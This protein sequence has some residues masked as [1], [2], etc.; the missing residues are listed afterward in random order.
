MKISHTWVTDP[1]SSQRGWGTFTTWIEIAG[2]MRGIRTGSEWMLNNNNE[3]G[4]THRCVDKTWGLG[5]TRLMRELPGSR[6]VCPAGNA[7]GHVAEDSVRRD[8]MKPQTAFSLS[9]SC[10]SSGC[11]AETVSRD[12]GGTCCCSVAKS[13]VTLCDPMNCST[14]DSLPFTIS[15]SSLKLMSF[16]SVML[17][18]Y[19]ILCSPL[20]LFSSLFPSIRWPKYWGFGFSINPSREYSGLISF[21]V[22]WFDLLAVQAT[23][24]S[25]LQHHNLKASV[26]QC[27]ASFM[28]KES[29]FTI[30]GPSRYSC[31]VGTD[32]RVCLLPRQYTW[33]GTVCSRNLGHPF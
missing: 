23:L 11:L 32:I 20:L 8:G 5:V 19:L 3:K 14:P 33:S 13:C 25:L 12:S 27:S 15:W 30:Q 24:K 28:V 10:L 17:S 6:S 31:V 9:L 1:L 22:D 21:R 26:F 4:K 29:I 2:R 7:K 18:N 16:E